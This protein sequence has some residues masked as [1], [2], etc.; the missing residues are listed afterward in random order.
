ML[1][2]GVEDEQGGLLHLHDDDG[3][4]LTTTPQSR[5]AHLAATTLL[6]EQWNLW[7]IPLDALPSGTSLAAVRLIAHTDYG[8]GWIQ[9]RVMAE[10]PGKNA[11]DGAD[12][13]ACV[14]TTRGTHSGRGFS[15]GSTLPAV[16][17]PHGMN[18]ITPVTNARTRRWLYRWHGD[19][20]P[21]LEAVALSHQPSPWI[22]DRGSMQV[23]PYLD[24]PVLEPR[25]RSRRFSHDD[26]V[27]QPDYYRVRLEG[28]IELELTATARTAAVRIHLPRAGGVTIDQ[29]FAGHLYA[30][31]TDTGVSLHGW[32]PGN[33]VRPSR[34]SPPR[35][36]FVGEIRSGTRIDTAYEDAGSVR[37]QA[38]H[39]PLSAGT[40]E[41]RLATSFISVEQAW[42]NLS[43]ESQGTFEELR[44][45]AHDAWSA[46]L[47]ALEL[48]GATAEQREAAYTGLYRLL[49]YPNIAHEN[50]GGP[51]TPRMVH[52]AAALPLDREHTD[53]VTGCR[54]LP[55][56]LYV[57]NGYWDTYRTCWP[58]YHL[59]MPDRAGV[60]LNGLLQTF[61]D[62]GWMGRWTAPGYIDCM[63][64]TDS[65]VIFADA[66]VHGIDFDQDTAYLSAL[67]NAMTPPAQTEVGRVGNR[68][69][70]FCDWVDSSIPEALS[71][72]V[73]NAIDD[74]A[75]GRWAGR[76]AH[77]ANGEA[78]SDL[79]AEAFYFTNRSLRWRCLFDPD[80]GFIRERRDDGMW[81][82]APAD[83]NPREWGGGYTETNG[84]G[85]AFSPVHDA[86]WLAD[87]L[88]GPAALGRRLDAYFQ[89]PEKAVASQRGTYG[90]IL[91]E[92]T[93]ARAL[94]MGQ[95][96]V[97]NQPA[98]HVPFMYLHSDR[99]DRAA[100]VLHDA[101]GRYF[102]GGRIGQ[103]WPGDEDNGEFSAWW[104][105]VAMGLYP[106]DV[107]SG[108]F[109]VT[110]PQLPSVRWTRSDGT[111]LS[112][113]R[114][115]SGKYIADV[116]VNGCALLA[117]V[118]RATA[119]HGDTHL[120][121]R[122]DTRPH[123]WGTGA[124]LASVSAGEYRRDKT[125]SG[126]LH[127][128]LQSAAALVD[129]AATTEVV[130]PPNTRLELELD[131]PEPARVFTLTGTGS[132]DVAVAVCA[133]G[134]WCRAAERRV[135]FRFPEETRVI[136][137]PAPPGAEPCIEAIRWLFPNGARLTQLEVI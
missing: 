82:V 47:A 77:R 130:L 51:D 81:K 106:L 75:I 21:R 115:G 109:V 100:E 107:G 14:R 76:L 120:R 55:G 28:G 48:S 78:R 136:A 88:G 54:I 79:L 56:E 13:V 72:T 65:D 19:P 89:D 125:R 15:R 38:A 67:R 96:A 114:E 66:A 11:Q 4:D 83:F 131:R 127:S 5:P 24:A 23:M 41:V 97:S 31:V 90:H 52:A 123:G 36:F 17:L 32:A 91:H 98:H 119:L 116:E 7:R 132:L 37:S 68:A 3:R 25:R 95:F 62:G 1:G 102:N 133:D 85:M 92:M 73:Q 84:W 124:R 113:T 117:P 42:Q 57:N 128:S 50:A 129:D 86:A 101:F 74:A 26:E 10:D 63:V 49:C 87:A 12:V 20:A 94:G 111:V 103:G 22:G 59:L 29:P 33:T 2:L 134:V 110:V 104:L 137:L 122:V 118:L 71:W 93:E 121:V 60:L 112:V 43:L 80:C 64:G 30:R 108:E 99:P 69:A 135:R 39:I 53:T 6:P 40:H 18:F 70:R 61:R 126:N 58:A 46:P 8:S 105:F 27:A 45:A 16:C 44:Q 35:V 9:A 34:P